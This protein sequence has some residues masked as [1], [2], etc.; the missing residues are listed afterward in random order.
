MKLTQ[1]PN[2]EPGQKTLL[3]FPPII[4]H[5][6]A[7]YLTPCLFCLF[8]LLLL[9]P[10]DWERWTPSFSFLCILSSSWIWQQVSWPV[11]TI[12]KNSI[13]WIS[14]IA[15]WVTLKFTLIFCLS[16]C[17]SVCLNCF[18]S[19]YTW[20]SNKKRNLSIINTVTVWLPCPRICPL[21][22][23]F[24]ILVNRTAIYSVAQTTNFRVIFDSSF[25]HIPTSNPSENP[26][27]SNFKIDLGPKTFLIISMV[28]ISI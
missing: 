25:S 18:L 20:I 28:T 1:S 21:F 15:M 10:Q 6:G 23:A 11:Y 8:P 17:L 3:A 26:I 5:I 24:L 19:L 14:S 13:V 22:Q 9:I 4:Q 27:G 16:L 7:S 12:E 2:W